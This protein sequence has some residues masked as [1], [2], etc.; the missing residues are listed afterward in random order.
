M[1]SISPS[2]MAQSANAPVVIL[3]CRSVLPTK[4]LPT[5]PVC[6]A[7]K[8]AQR[9]A[10]GWIFTKLFRQNRKNFRNFRPLYLEFFKTKSAFQ[11]KY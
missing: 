10:P 9:Y 4:I 2:F 7:R 6:T 1:E 8:Y 3:R 5:L 11:S